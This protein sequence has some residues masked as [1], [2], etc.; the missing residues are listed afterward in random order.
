MQ[1]AFR[2]GDCKQVRR[3]L[4]Y[5]R[6]HVPEYNEPIDLDEDQRRPSAIA[7]HRLTAV[8]AALGRTM[9]SAR[10]HIEPLDEALDNAALPSDV[11][12]AAQDIEWSDDDDAATDQVEAFL[13]EHC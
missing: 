5:T 11:I 4:L 6:L 3:R 1:S 8:G 12:A 13:K 9:Q 10:I 7:S 2:P